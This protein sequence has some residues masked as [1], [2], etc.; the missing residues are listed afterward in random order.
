MLV[1]CIINNIDIFYIHTLTHTVIAHSSL[2]SWA[3]ISPTPI[4]SPLFPSCHPWAAAEWQRSSTNEGS[5]IKSAS[6]TYYCPLLLPWQPVEEGEPRSTSVLSP[7]LGHSRLMPISA[8]QC[9]FELVGSYFRTGDYFPKRPLLKYGAMEERLMLSNTPMKICA[10]KKRKFASESSFWYCVE[11]VFNYLFSPL[12]LSR[13]PVEACGQY[14]S[15]SECLG[16][17]DPHCGWCVL[18]NT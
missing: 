9:W 10:D 6:K 18:H 14:S 2:S 16:S 13:V 11:I 4:M 15:C 8:S 5:L 17:G 7:E 12:Q 1:I 3:F